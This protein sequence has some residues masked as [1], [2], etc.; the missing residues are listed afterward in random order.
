MTP[1]PPSCR[2]A[3]AIACLITS[4]CGAALIGLPQASAADTKATTPSTTAAEQNA[5]VGDNYVIIPLRTSLQR[6]L[7]ANGRTI[8]AL[9]ELNG[10]ALLGKRGDDLLRE[11]GVD[12]LRTSLADIKSADPRASISLVVGYFGTA[13]NEMFNQ[14]RKDNGPLEAACRALAAEARLRVG[15]VSFS[16]DSTPYRWGKMVTAVRAVDLGQETADENPIA[17]AHL[18]AYPV[19]TAVSRLLTDDYSTNTS[20]P[21]D[22]VLY[23]RDRLDGTDGNPLIG[24][25]LEAQIKSAVE[26]LSLPKKVRIDFHL[27]LANHSPEH[28]QQNRDAVSN[29]F[30]GQKG[31]AQHLADQ[32]GFQK[33]T[34][35]Y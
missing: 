34:V 30:V 21:A 22:C 33:S 12:R 10:Y 7:V 5:T 23:I 20:S 15:S 31:E 4:F 1:S 11:I 3:I 26:K 19:R 35:T 25:E 13:T 32:L 17:N 14:A 9:V 29:R 16:Y 18:S 24:P 28:Y 6:R 2:R 8:K 27:D